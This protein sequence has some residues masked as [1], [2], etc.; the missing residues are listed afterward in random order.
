MKLLLIEDDAKLAEH[1]GQNLKEHGFVVKPVGAVVDLKEVL[2]SSTPYEFI[3]M[4]RLLGATDSK[5]FLPDIKKKW[6][7]APII[8]LSAI[9]TPNERTDLINLGADDYLGKPFS[10]QE[11]IARMRSLLRRSANPVGNFL[12][13][14]DLVVD[15]IRRVISVG[16]RAENLPTREFALLRTLAQDPARVWSKDELLDYVWG[17]NANVDTNVVESTIANVRRKLSEIGASVTIRNM[18][19]AGYWIAK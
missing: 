19:N 7:M 3:L 18:R 11:L 8:V 9:S 13:V 1:L 14:D 17:H 16:D 6:P 2:T 10:T 15:L 12:Q 5:V 4:D